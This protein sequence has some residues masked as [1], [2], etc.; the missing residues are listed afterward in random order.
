MRRGWETRTLADRP[1]VLS[2]RMNWGTWVLLPQPVSPDTTTTRAEETAS[3][4]ASRT[5][6]AGRRWRWLCML[7]HAGLLARRAATAAKPSFVI[8]VGAA[9]GRR[10]LLPPFWST[11]WLIHCTSRGVTSR[12]GPSTAL[13]SKEATTSAGR[14]RRGTSKGSARAWVSNRETRSCL[15]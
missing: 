10:R 4:T 8:G 5:F 9:W 6:Q 7:R 2:S 15:A 13:L 1:S 3:M 11:P 14:A 12:E